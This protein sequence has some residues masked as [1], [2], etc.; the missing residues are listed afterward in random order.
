M[1]SLLALP[2]IALLMTTGAANVSADT[3]PERTRGTI[4]RSTDST[5][6]ERGARDHEESTDESEG[7]Q[8]SDNTGTVLTVTSDSGGILD[9]KYETTG[10]DNSDITV[11]IN[12]QVVS[13]TGQQ[14]DDDATTNEGGADGED[15]A[16]GSEDG[17]DESNV[18]SNTDTAAEEDTESGDRN[19]RPNHDR[20][21]RP[22]PR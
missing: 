21:S 19:D 12:G 1:K 3:H 4:T 11:T 16:G 18:D 2:I 17:T 9:I 10:D 8:P 22:T 6:T 7:E 15:G 5:P 20:G 13:N 14:G